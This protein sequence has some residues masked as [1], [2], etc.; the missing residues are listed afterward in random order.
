MCYPLPY[1][2][3]TK[4]KSIIPG[5]ASQ[6]QREHFCNCRSSG[7][8]RIYFCCPSAAQLLRPLLPAFVYP[9]FFL[10]NILNARLN[11]SRALSSHSSTTY[12]IS[13]HSSPFPRHSSSLCF[14]S[15]NLPIFTKMCQGVRISGWAC[16]CDHVEETVLVQQGFFIRPCRQHEVTQTYCTGFD[17]EDHT[18]PIPVGCN[19]CYWKTILHNWGPA[20]VYFRSFRTGNGLLFREHCP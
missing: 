18:E 13:P 19:K 17:R 5:T 4:G 6:G 15:I 16:G 12:S 2:R 11:P 8:C 1:V 9:N 10:S 7:K 3:I 20:S 14:S